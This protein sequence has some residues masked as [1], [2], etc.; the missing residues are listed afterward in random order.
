[1]PLVSI[2]IPCYNADRWLVDTLESALSQTW[3]NCE[4]ILVDDGSTDDSLAIARSFEHRGVRVFAQPNRGA[5][6]ARNWARH[7]ARGD[8]IQ[9]LDADDLLLPDKIARQIEA[10]RMA[11]GAAALVSGEWARF[12]DNPDTATIHADKL[13]RDNDAISWETL[14]LSGNLM[15][16]PAAW[17]MTRELSDATGEWNESLT[18]NDDGEYFSRARFAAGNIQFVT[19]ARS[20]YRSGIPHSLS[21]PHSRRALES[22]FLSHELIHRLLLDHENS[23]RTR[24]ACADAWMHFAFVSAPLAPDLANRAE[25]ASTAMGGSNLQPTGGR[26]FRLTCQATGWRQ[27]VRLR[28]LLNFSRS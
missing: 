2:L 3:P 11:G 18:L 9:Y 26:I 7:E 22:A 24:Q 28:H 1:M 21:S 15:M 20:L 17:L 14:A 13:W 5:C 23:P 16:H 10:L 12:K 27:A 6:A 19:G 8:F 25:Q 4:T